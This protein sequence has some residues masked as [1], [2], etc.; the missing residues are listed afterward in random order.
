MKSA[1]KHVSAEGQKGDKLMQCKMEAQLETFVEKLSTLDLAETKGKNDIPSFQ[2]GI[3]NILSTSEGGVLP[4]AAGLA[5][6]GFIGG[7]VNRFIPLGALALPVA[8][9]LM[10]KFF[11][12]GFMAGMAKGI[13]AAGI[14]SFFG[15]LGGMLGGV[16]GG[17]GQTAGV[18]W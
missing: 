6:S 5:L 10:M 15:G 12:G 9:F 3:G 14:A 17:Q 8:G 16:L 13:I 11:K 2:E 18:V 1:L 7:L 4:L